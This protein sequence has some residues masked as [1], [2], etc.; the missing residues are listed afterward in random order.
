MNLHIQNGRLIDPANRLDTH[1]DLFIAD[2]KIVGVGSAPAGFS[3]GRVIDARG[4]VVAPGLIDLA[5]RLR[6]PGFEYKATLESEMDAAMAGGITSLAIPPDTDPVLDEPGL[7]EMLCYRAKKLNRAHVYPVG[8]LTIG[9]KGQQLSEMA[10]LVEAGCVAFSQANVPIVDTRVL[11]RAML[12]AATFG[13]RLW[14]QPIDPHLSRGG[15]A[16]DGEVA[17]RLGLPGIP[18]AAETV[19]LYTYLQLARLTGARLHITRLSSADSLDHIEQARRDGVDV[20]CDVAAHALHLSDMDIGYFNPHCHVI[21]PLRSQ[22]D[23]AALSKAVAE[24]RINAICSDH[25]PVDD[26]AKQA[27][28]SESE[29]GN[30]GL[31]LLL[32]LTLKWAGEHG[33]PLLDAL[34]RITSDAAKIAGIAKGGH[35]SVGARADVCV[36]DPEAYQ[37]ITRS[38]LKSQGKNTPF[39]GL[40]L[41][42]KVRYTLVEGSLMYEAAA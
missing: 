10:E 38:L 35:L 20:T 22:R 25:T 24:G 19:A 17:S 42:G 33:L 21:P 14:L 7:V 34:A 4:L 37:L 13:F 15:V 36:F 11:Y 29:P 16:H 6:E 31:E 23:R 28:F 26:D 30:T 2:G 27:P 18:A 5:A 3:A 39:L 8:A 32:P 40:E 12:Y 9:L 1:Q 41:P